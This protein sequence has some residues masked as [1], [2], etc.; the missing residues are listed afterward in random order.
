MY[1]A[2]L[3][4]GADSKSDDDIAVFDTDDFTTVKVNVY[5]LIKLGIKV[6]NFDY[7]EYHVEHINFLPVL[8]KIVDYAEISGHDIRIKDFV[9]FVND[10]DNYV[11]YKGECTEFFLEHFKFNLSYAFM[12]SG[13]LVMRFKSLV[14][15]QW[16]TL[17]VNKTGVVANW[18]YN[19][20]LNQRILEKGSKSFMLQVDTLLE[21]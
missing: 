1:L 18:I 9:F 15:G 19:K 16:M 6:E 5:E 3:R 12:Y 13:C 8:S 10:I 17:A 2:V 20:V 7:K 21:V 4:Y 14:R 11:Y